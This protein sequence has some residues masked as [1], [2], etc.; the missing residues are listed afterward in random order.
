MVLRQGRSFD[1]LTDDR[2]IWKEWITFIY[3]LKCSVPKIV[4]DQN[5]GNWGAFRTRLFNFSHVNEI[6]VG[7]A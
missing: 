3:C 1:E 5:K 4:S 6:H 2:N 7:P